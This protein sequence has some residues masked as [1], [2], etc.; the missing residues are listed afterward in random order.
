MASQSI[1]SGLVD[2]SPMAI[3][4]ELTVVRDEYDY[5]AIA[6]CSSCGKALPVSQRW[7]T[8]SADNLRWF[9]DQFRLHVEYEHPGWSGLPRI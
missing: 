4:P 9:A 5:P 1:G 7:I 6:R 8:S 3:K 2:T